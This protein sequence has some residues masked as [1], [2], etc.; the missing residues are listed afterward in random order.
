M[1]KGCG[2]PMDELRRVMSIGKT[3][4]PVT[5]EV[6]SELT[7]AAIDKEIQPIIAAYNGP[8]VYGSHDYERRLFR[9]GWEAGMLART[10]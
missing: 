7:D 6:I 10:K 8:N 2:A 4:G 9:A 3:D 1:G 5:R